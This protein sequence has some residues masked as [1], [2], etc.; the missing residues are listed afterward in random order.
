MTTNPA[1]AGPWLIYGARSFA[2]TVADLLRDAGQD[3]LG[4]FDDVGQPLDG[5]QPFAG[6]LPH[7]VQSYGSRRPAVALGIG[8]NDLSARWSAWQRLRAL[9]WP[10]PAVVHP[11]AYVARTAQLSEGCL[12]MAGAIVDRQARLGEASVLWPAACVNHEVDIGHNCFV[13][14]NATICGAATIGPHSFVGAGVLVADHCAVP[15]G[16]FL[17]MGTRFTGRPA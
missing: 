12:V 17:K 16:S 4:F 1:D 5:V 2:L 8:Y 13:S 11:R 14:P 10:L 7:V 6:S 3:V 15:T 9:G